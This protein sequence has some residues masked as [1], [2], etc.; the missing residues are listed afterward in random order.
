MDYDEL[1]KAFSEEQ[2]AEETMGTNK[3]KSKVRAKSKRSTKL[4]NEARKRKYKKSINSAVIEFLHG[5]HHTKRGISMSCSARVSTKLRKAVAD[6][7]Q[8]VSEL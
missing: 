6:F 8:A 2:K 7:K 1:L 3:T 5:I 4:D